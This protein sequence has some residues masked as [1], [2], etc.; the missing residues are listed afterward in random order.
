MGSKR[1]KAATQKS[2]ATKCDPGHQIAA[3]CRNCDLEEL[4]HN[5]NVILAIRLLPAA[6]I[7]TLNYWSTKEM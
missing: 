6:E 1:N 5:K 4:E 7:V 2:S 3:S